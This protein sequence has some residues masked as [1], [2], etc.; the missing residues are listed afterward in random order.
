VRRLVGHEFRLR[1]ELGVFHF[2]AKKKCTVL[3]KKPNSATRRSSKRALASA[4]ALKHTCTVYAY[5]FSSTDAASRLLHNETPNNDFTLTVSFVISSKWSHDP[6]PVALRPPLDASN[7]LRCLLFF[8]TLNWM[9]VHDS[10]K[11]LM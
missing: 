8:T 11:F 10:N 5:I 4:G 9:F 6:N 3:Q 2:R 7:S 1:F